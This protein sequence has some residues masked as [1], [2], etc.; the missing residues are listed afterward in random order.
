MPSWAEG[1]RSVET[2]DRLIASVKPATITR[3]FAVHDVD[4]RP[5]GQAATRAPAARK[6]CAVISQIAIATISYISFLNAASER[7]LK[8]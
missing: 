6:K 1:K 2:L 8:P 5:Y 4:A 3:E 7:N